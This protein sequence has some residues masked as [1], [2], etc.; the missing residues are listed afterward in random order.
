M[1]FIL[2]IELHNVGPVEQIPPGEGRKYRVEGEEIAV[3][4]TLQG[5]I[6]AAEAQCRHH[7][8]PLARARAENRRTTWPPL[9]REAGSV[10]GRV[11]GEECFPLRSYRVAVSPNGDLLLGAKRGD[12]ALCD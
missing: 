6:F 5:D 11:G 10:G 3:F 12:I 8:G 4:R 9:G 2:G 1:S 7:G